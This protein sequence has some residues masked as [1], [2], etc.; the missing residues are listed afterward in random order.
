MM[1]EHGA[2]FQLYQEKL[3]ELAPMLGQLANASQVIWL[4]QYPTA[5]FNGEKGNLKNEIHSEK[6]HH[7][8]KAIRRILGYVFNLS[9][10]QLVK[11]F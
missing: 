8:N 11:S 9:S 3:T 5:D 1:R 6:I 2:D 10:I 7:Y 4:N